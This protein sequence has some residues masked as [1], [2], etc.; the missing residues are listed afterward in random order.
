[1]RSIKNKKFQ[2]LIL[3]VMFQISIPRIR[4]RVVLLPGILCAAKVRILL[5]QPCSFLL[6]DTFFVSLKKP[7]K[8]GIPQKKR[9][10]ILC[11]GR[12]REQLAQLGLLKSCKDFKSI[13]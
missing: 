9:A 5:A 7:T 11:E 4:L 8:V 1:M 6:R 2:T 13:E 12:L 3:S 10:R